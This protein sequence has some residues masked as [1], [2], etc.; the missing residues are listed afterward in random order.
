[1]K[2]LEIESMRF[3][4][5]FVKNFPPGMPRVEELQLIN[6]AFDSVEQFLNFSGAFSSLKS[7]SIDGLYVSYDLGIGGETPHT[8]QLGT[9]QSGRV[10]PPTG[11]R[12]LS[13]KPSPP[14]PRF[15]LEMLK[16][17][18]VNNAYGNL[19]R[20]DLSLLQPGYVP[21]VESTLQA[22][23]VNLRE[24]SIGFCPRAVRDWDGV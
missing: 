6:C 21:L 16:W 14:H 19:T 3:T 7:I 24:M 10:A 5:E 23:G 13:L 8:D 2:S 17:L 22:V 1:M 15:V 18:T 11:I 9:P 20:L 12:D 4:K